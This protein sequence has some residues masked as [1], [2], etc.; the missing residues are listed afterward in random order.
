MV[1]FHG[2]RCDWGTWIWGIISSTRTWRSEFISIVSLLP[3]LSPRIS[4]SWQMRQM[5][6]HLYWETILIKHLE[7]SLFTRSRNHN[8][9]FR[10]THRTTPRRSS[11]VDSP[12]L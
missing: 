9:L 6:V 7:V 1:D 5:G 2:Y 8:V 4:Y 11:N 3:H 12:D 10:N